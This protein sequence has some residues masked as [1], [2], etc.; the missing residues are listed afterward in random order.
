MNEENLKNNNIPP[1]ENQDDKKN[2]LFN[3]I[4][5]ISTLLIAIL[6]AT[7]AYFSATARSKEND[8]S[9][10]SAYV[11][12]EYDGGTEIKA[13]DLIPSTETIALKH[14]QKE[15]P[16]DGTWTIEGQEGVEYVDRD[17]LARCIDSAGRQVCYAYQFTI[18][19]DG[20]EGG[21]TEILGS[22]KI[23]T[24]DFTN[25]SYLVYEVE[26]EKDSNNNE[27][28]DKYGNKVIKSYT[29]LNLSGDDVYAVAGTPNF[30]KFEKPSFKIGEN[31]ELSEV[32]YPVACLFGYKD[33]ELAVDDTKRCK[34]YTISNKQEHTFQVLIWLNETGENQDKEQGNRFGGTVSIEVI[35]GLD[36]TTSDGRITGKE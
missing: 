3:I 36:A 26:I 25:L 7:F 28:I 21:N 13:E 35:G 34:T 9:L 31:E 19:S 24:N 30:W 20:I 15:V 17:S 27:Y 29:D 14:Y 6:G 1:E 16:D 11:S 4:L 33:E 2:N 5:G 12:I 10:K 22:I 8:V 23:N 32:I 18:T